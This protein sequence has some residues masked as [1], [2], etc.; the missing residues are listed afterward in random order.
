[1][2]KTQLNLEF[3]LA[4]FF[5]DQPMPRLQGTVYLPS[6][7]VGSFVGW[8]GVLGLGHCVSGLV[9]GTTGQVTLILSQHFT[10]SP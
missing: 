2:L 6:Y 10:N 8:V 4:D 9:T 5:Y 1:M 7:V 3:D